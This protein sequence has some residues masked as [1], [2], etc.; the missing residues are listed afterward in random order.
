MASVI[1]PMA[2]A[3]TPIDSAQNIDVDG[4]ERL[5]NLLVKNE[6]SIFALGSAGEGMNLTFSSSRN[7]YVRRS[8]PRKLVH[9]PPRRYERLRKSSD[10]LWKTVKELMSIW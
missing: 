9:P 1:G 2:V 6:L 10:K 5:V 7:I 3:P 4:I 8:H